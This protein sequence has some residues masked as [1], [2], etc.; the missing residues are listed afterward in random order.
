[1]F[2]QIENFTFQ[3]EGKILGFGGFSQVVGAINKFDNKQYAIKIVDVT[4]LA[5]QD[6]EN[7]KN[8]IRI[9][10]QILHP[11]IVYFHKAIQEESLVFIILEKASNGCLFFYIDSKEGLPESLAVRT[12][13]QI[14]TAIQYLHK[15]GII[16]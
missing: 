13:F 15:Q 1:M 4:K 9:H 16:H 3:E 8:E 11:N 12:L 5:P 7:L 10:Q 14:G 2:T 6:I